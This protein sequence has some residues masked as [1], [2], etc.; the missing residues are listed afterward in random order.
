MPG[1]L[2]VAERLHEGGHGRQP[3]VQAAQRTTRRGATLE[4]GQEHRSAA[5]SRCLPPISIGAFAIHRLLIQHTKPLIHRLL[6]FRLFDQVQIFLPAEAPPQVKQ[7]FPVRRP[8]NLHQGGVQRVAEHRLHR[9]QQPFQGAGLGH[10]GLNP[11]SGR[12]VQLLRPGSLPPPIT[13]KVMA[14]ARSFWDQIQARDPGHVV[15]GDQQIIMGLSSRPGQAF[16]QFSAV[17]TS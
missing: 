5:V 7:P 6:Q 14:S 3:M 1:G 16:T 15:F 12:P 11:Q 8:N 9:F 10:H 2:P 4:A 17:S 13:G